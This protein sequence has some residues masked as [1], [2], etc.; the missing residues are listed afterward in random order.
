MYTTYL[1]DFYFFFFFLVNKLLWSEGSQLRDPSLHIV[2]MT[3]LFLNRTNWNV[4]YYGN[5][6]VGTSTQWIKVKFSLGPH[7]KD[8]WDFFP[9]AKQMGIPEWTSRINAR[10]TVSFGTTTFQQDVRSQQLSTRRRD[11]KKYISLGEFATGFM[12][13]ASG[14]FCKCWVRMTRSNATSRSKAILPES[15][16][17][18]RV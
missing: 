6:H 14:K 7:S 9:L 10:A 3:D 16:N 13:T 15:I 2:E 8:V 12:H 11:R 18:P 1:S 17:L 5:E 4:F